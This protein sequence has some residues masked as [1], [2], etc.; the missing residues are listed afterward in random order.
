MRRGSC[1]LRKIDSGATASGRRDDRAQHEPDGPRQA[2]EP[3][4]RRRDRDGGEHDASDRQQRDRTQIEAEL[5]PAHRHRGRVDDGRQHQEQN[6]L[7]RELDRRAG[8][9]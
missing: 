2:E 4:G 9:G 7:G 3:M 6:Q 8:R 5:V 1:I